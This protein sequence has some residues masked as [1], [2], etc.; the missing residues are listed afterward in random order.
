MARQVDEQ[1]VTDSERVSAFMDG[2][3]GDDAAGEVVRHCGASVALSDEWSLYHC[4]GDVMRSEDMSCHSN[5]LESAVAARL[6]SEPHL[7]A[8]APARMA[9]PTLRRH[10]SLAAAVSAVA[11]LT[12]LALPQ[13]NVQSDQ[14]AALASPALSQMDSALRVPAT[15]ALPDVHATVAKNSVV[16]GAPRVL[17]EY[18]AAHRQYSGGLALG[19]RPGQMRTIAFEAG[20]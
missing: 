9:N 10:V 14:T 7:L 18:L 5:R 1:S 6:A 12:Y 8:P 4:I 11:I 16:A 19:G 20:K 13:W 15:G 17:S 3:L 2:E